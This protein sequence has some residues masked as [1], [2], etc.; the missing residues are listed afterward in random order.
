MANSPVLEA[1]GITKSFGQ[2]RANIDVGLTLQRGEIRGLVGE[3]GA[4]KSTLAHILSGFHQADGGTIAVKGQDVQIANS[5][6]A[7]DLGIGI[8][9]QHFMLVAGFSALDNILLGTGGWRLNFTRRNAREK[10]D[11][12]AS[13][14]GLGVDLNTRV[15]DLTVGEQQRV[16]ILKALYRSA[17]IL[18][19]DEP[20]AVLT[21]D[22]ADHLFE[23]LRELAAG[24]TAIV[25]VTHKLREVMDL[26]HTVSVM[27]QGRI[28]ADLK[29][30]E[31][32]EAELAALMVGRR[33]ELPQITDTHA[34]SDIALHASGIGY[35]DSMGVRRLDDVSL[36]LRRGEIVGIA[37]VAGNGQSELVGILTGMLNPTSGTV[38]LGTRDVTGMDPAEM[39][40]AGVAHV[41]EDR[42]RY[43]LIAGMSLSENAALGYSSHD[44]FGHGPQ[45]SPAAAKRV[46]RRLIDI[47]DTRPPEPGARAGSLSGGNQQKIVMAREIDRNPDIL[48]V[49]Q[50]T[51]GVDIGAIAQMHSALLDLRKSGKAVLLVSVE[52]DEIRA[53]SDR[54]LVMCAGRITGELP[55]TAPEAEIGHLM[56]GGSHG[57]V[58]IDKVAGATP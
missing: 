54:I 45:F 16:E 5:H 36:E 48:I 12:I 58:A 4:G 49:A 56:A 28:V 37:G 40:L 53:M 23:V 17:D 26:T 7:I 50:P 46:A 38:R 2:V 47:F 3:N 13:R 29:T 15:A 8:V 14:F 11:A 34:Q 20:T 10:L 30:P 19:L 1:S 33:V 32:D 27:R 52:L 41:P 25:V 44:E 35:T 31:T 6:H 43:G 42:L 9:H 39:R 55:R 21:P 24:G 51:R 18:L 22:E 57:V